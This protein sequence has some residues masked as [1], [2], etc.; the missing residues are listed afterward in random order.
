MGFRQGNQGGGHC[1]T[2]CA[3]RAGRDRGRVDDRV[4]GGGRSRAN[5][6]SRSWPGRSGS[7][8][9]PACVIA[10]VKSVWAERRMQH[11]SSG[12]WRLAVRRGQTGACG[13]AIVGRHHRQRR[14]G[15]SRVH[16]PC[17]APGRPGLRLLSSAGL[18]QVDH[19]TVQIHHI[20]PDAEWRGSVIEI[21]LTEINRVDFGGELGRGAFSCRKVASWRVRCARARV[22]WAPSKDRRGAAS[23]SSRGELPLPKSRSGSRWEGPAPRLQEA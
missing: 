10:D 9:S 8:A 5:S 13:P 23:L 11:S 4:C 17:A 1:R 6:P 7:M 12:R 20:T 16:R 3:R 22:R 15:V 21:P 14:E 2:T 19:A 18:A